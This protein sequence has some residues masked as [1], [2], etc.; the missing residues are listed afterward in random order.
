MELNSLTQI[1]LFPQALFAFVL[2]IAEVIFVNFDYFGFMDN[3]NNYFIFDYLHYSIFFFC[4]WWCTSAFTQEYVKSFVVS[5][6]VFY[7]KQ[8]YSFVIDRKQIGE[9]NI[10]PWTQY[11]FFFSLFITPIFSKVIMLNDFSNCELFFAIL[12]MFLISNLSIFS[13][14]T[15]CIPQAITICTYVNKYIHVDSSKSKRFL[16][17]NLLLGFQIFLFLSVCE[18]F[19]NLY[20]I[21]I[22]R[23][24]QT[25]ICQ[26]GVRLI[27]GQSYDIYPQKIVTESKDLSYFGRLGHFIKN[28]D[29]YQVVIIGYILIS[30]FYKKFKQYYENCFIIVAILSLLTPS[31]K[32]PYDSDFSAYEI[33][34]FIFKTYLL[35]AFATECKRL[36]EEQFIVGVLLTSLFTMKHNGHFL[37]KLVL[38]I[39]ELK[40]FF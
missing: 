17:K 22:E 13:L 12:L 16:K 39:S 1:F 15:S 33:H 19:P 21:L 18:L 38:Y 11:L 9:E 35:I 31:F 10:P 5:F 8:I 37:E 14:Y 2:L 28:D 23:L 3:A 40:D 6:F 29:E 24:Q 36:K 32:D 30:F 27:T 7:D 20:Q 4:F 34:F 26:E 25:R